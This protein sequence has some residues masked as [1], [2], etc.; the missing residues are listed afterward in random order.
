MRLALLYDVEKGLEDQP[1]TFASPEALALGRKDV[2]VPMKLPRP[3]QPIA[4]WDLLD[5]RERRF[6]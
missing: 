6:G 5:A 2:R 3:A 1:S 4:L